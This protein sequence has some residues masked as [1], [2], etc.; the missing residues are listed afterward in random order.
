MARRPRQYD[1]DDEYVPDLPSTTRAVA[2]GALFFSGVALVISLATLFLTWRDGVLAKNAILLSESISQ[3]WRKPAAPRPAA[4]KTLPKDQSATASSPTDPAA[5]ATPADGV[6][7]LNPNPTEAAKLLGIRTRLE[8]L[9]QKVRNGDGDAALNLEQLR[10]ELEGLNHYASD[11]TT[12][13]VRPALDKL[14]YAREQLQQNGP[15]AAAMLKVLANDL[16]ARLGSKSDAGAAPDAETTPRPWPTAAAEA[17]PEQEP[18]APESA[19]LERQGLK[20]YKPT[21]SRRT[22]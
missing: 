5:E 16:Q 22:E 14:R 1:L 8:E 6:E 11:A 15:Q 9:A 13:W 4:G 20:E 19:P 18:A 10:R 12:R 7:P 2:W 3:H 21:T 17:L